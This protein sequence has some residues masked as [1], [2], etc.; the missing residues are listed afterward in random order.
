MGG[1][2]RKEMG[3]DIRG[4]DKMG[5][6][7]EGIGSFFDVLGHGSGGS[8]VGGSL[9]GM[10]DIRNAF[11]MAPGPMHPVSQSPYFLEPRK[12]S[13]ESTFLLDFNKA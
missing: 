10:G 9:G 11:V 6:P 2:F 7:D 8:A 5:S 12:E 4:Y 3:K 1:S 13:T